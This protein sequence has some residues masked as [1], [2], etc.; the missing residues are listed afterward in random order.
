MRKEVNFDENQYM[1]ELTEFSAKGIEPGQP[2]FSQGIADFANKFAMPPMKIKH[3]LERI[4][5]GIAEK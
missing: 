3:D 1:A 5:H 4:K 2:G